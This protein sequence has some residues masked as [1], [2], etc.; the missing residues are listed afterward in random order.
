MIGV[1]PNKFK[2]IKI[3]KNNYY[4]KLDEILG[5]YESWYNQNV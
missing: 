1:N 5:Y 4:F 2:N 3:I